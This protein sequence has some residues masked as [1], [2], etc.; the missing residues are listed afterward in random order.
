MCV[1]GFLSLGI[2]ERSSKWIN[3]LLVMKAHWDCSTVLWSNY[4]AKYFIRQWL[5]SLWNKTKSEP[6]QNKIAEGEIAKTLGMYM[7]MSLQS[8]TTLVFLTELKWMICMLQHMLFLKLHLMGKL[9]IEK[10][11]IKI[12]ILQHADTSLCRIDHLVQ[13][14]RIHFGDG[15][16]KKIHLNGKIGVSLITRL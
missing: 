6:I 3:I 11:I 16:E 15:F 5:T 8:L 10:D 1:P 2:W 7:Y 13:I 12:G 9:S 4:F 14:D